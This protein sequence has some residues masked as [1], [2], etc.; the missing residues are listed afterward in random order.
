MDQQSDLDAQLARAKRQLEAAE[1]APDKSGKRATAGSSR[2]PLPM[3]VV[4]RWL[5]R[6]GKLLMTI[7]NLLTFPYWLW[8]RWR[9]GAIGR[10]LAAVWN[11]SAYR[12][13]AGE[14]VLD[15]D[16]ERIF[17][18]RRLGTISGLVLALGFGLYVGWC[19][20]YFYGTQ[21]TELVYTTGKGEIIPGEKYQISACT[22]LPCSTDADNGMYYSIE[23]SMFLPTL[24]Y[25][26]QDVYAN[27]Q[28]GEVCIVKG[29]GIY[30]RRLRRLFKYAEW[31]QHIYNVS[32]RPLTIEERQKALELGKQIEERSNM[33][34]K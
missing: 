3:G 11:F 31:Y 20:L 12:H 10:W 5:V 34:E 24:Y 14:Q 16:G 28:M 22:S 17:S 2:Q 4:A 18:G 29:Y 1:A 8:R 26:E 33:H 23:S 7:I 13:E 30:F 15:K 19:A 27:T 25:P 9:D 21:F 32:C 6:G